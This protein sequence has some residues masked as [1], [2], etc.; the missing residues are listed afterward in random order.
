[1]DTG[2]RVYRL[3]MEKQKEDTMVEFGATKTEVEL[4]LKI[5]ERLRKRL[6]RP[7]G[8]AWIATRRDL[9][10]DLDACHSNGCPLDFK[11][12]LEFPALDFAHDVTEIQR[13]LN[14]GTG[15][16]DGIFKPRCAR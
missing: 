11:Q 14:R 16:I 4:I 6:K 10:M 7:M 5:A 12:L 8:R 13:H 3:Y 15:K 2:R 9:V 1:M